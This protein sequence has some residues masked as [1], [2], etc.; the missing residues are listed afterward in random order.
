[1][2][3]GI[4]Q[5]RMLPPVNN[6][7]QEF[8]SDWKQEIDLM[9]KHG[10]QHV[11]WLITKNSFAHNPI[12]KEDDFNFHPLVSSICVDNLVDKRIVDRDYFFS[13]LEPVCAAAQNRG[14]RNITIP[15][16]EDSSMEDDES[17]TIFCRLMLEISK[18]YPNI[19]FCFEAELSHEKLLEILNESSNFYVTYDTGNITSYG[20]DHEIYLNKL[21]KFIRNV[22]LKDRTYDC[23]TVSPGTGDTNFKL[24]FQILKKIGYNG[25]Y[26]IQT[27][28]AKSGEE[29]STILKHKKIF[30]EIYNEK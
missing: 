6:H 25:P 29:V 12:F 13:N 30:E 2:K 27:A 23:K 26:T 16:L 10:L 4:M 18:K 1:M 9:Q 8:P 3:I 28:R 11:E 14:I 24:I 7:I 20:E 21:S 5:G 17:R 19:N 22:H 15:I